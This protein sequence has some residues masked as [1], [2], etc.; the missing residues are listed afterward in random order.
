MEK[1]RDWSAA[2]LAGG[3]A[4][5]FGGRD[6]GSLVIE[7]RSIVERQIDALSRIAGDLLLVGGR[8]E[9]ARRLGVRHATD[10]VPG[11]GP[12]GGI[13]AALSAATG[14]ALLVVACDMPYVS[15]PLGARLLALTAGAD[16]VVPYTE[17]GYHP[18]CA[19][20][21][22]A[23]LEPIA[24]RLAEGRLK[25]ADLVGDLRVR[26][27]TVHELSAFGDPERLLANVNTPDEYRS[28]ATN[29]P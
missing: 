7:G 22:R 19:A 16:L 14:A 18:L 13:H 25:L 8:P 1:S 10:L 21:T 5:R 9:T 11:C 26:V 20:Y 4:T 2:I 23:C 29:E 27:V 6:K 24:R 15:A 17:R 12:M 28:I 3:L